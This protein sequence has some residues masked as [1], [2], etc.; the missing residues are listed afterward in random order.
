MTRKCNAVFSGGGVKGI[1]FAGAITA[2]ENAGYSFNSLAGVSAGAIVAALLATG[3]SAG[4]IE[5]ETQKIEYSKFL[6]NGIF[7]TF[8]SIGKLLNC[9][10]YYG[11]YKAD[12]FENLL[13]ELLARKGKHT[14]GD[15]KDHSQTGVSKYKL[16]VVAADIT[17]KE[18]LVLPDDIARFG[19]EPDA[20]SIAKAVRMSMSLPLF[21]EPYVL[22]R[23]GRK[24]VI[25]DGGLL[26]AYPIWLFNDDA[27]ADIPTFGF[28]FQG[29]DKIDSSMEAPNK[30]RNFAE[31]SEAVV[32]TLIEAHDKYHISKSSGDFERSV[33]I[34]VEVKTA[35]GVKKIATTSFDINEE[36][37]IALYQNGK[38][39]AEKFLN[40]WSFEHW[41]KT[42][43]PA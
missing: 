25:V 14:F 11:L 19:I 24:H 31:Y 23:Y 20:L 28:K 41:K 6:N 22:K 36:E 39:A 4:E 2:F 27:K 32:S 33:I 15:I 18:M 13:C 17:Y 21:F 5:E 29:D 37:R 35:S 3:Y 10:L 40:G 7:T 38:K 8:G 26:S 16:R 12:Y 43:R 9:A 34:P 1:G 42:Y 30:T